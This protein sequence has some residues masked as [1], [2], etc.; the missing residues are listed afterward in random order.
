MSGPVDVLAVLDAASL[1]L[2][3]MGDI[4]RSRATKIDEARAA[5]AEL[6]ETH[7]ALCRHFVNTLESGRDR[8]IALGGDCDPVDRMEQSD[9]VLA[10]SRA[11]LAN[12]GGAK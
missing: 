2:R 4:G 6:I 1:S 9:P 11:A 12:V 5:V 3:K 8:I 7:K 10:R